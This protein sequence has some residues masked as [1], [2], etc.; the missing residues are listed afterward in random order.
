MFNKYPLRFPSLQIPLGQALAEVSDAARE[1]YINSIDLR[2]KPVGPDASRPCVAE[3]LREFWKTASAARQTAL[4]TLAFKRWKDWNFDAGNGATHVFD[5]CWCEIDYAVMG[6]VVEC[7][8]AKARAATVT[9][10]NNR[11]VALDNNWH[12]SLSDFYSAFNRLVSALQPYLHA[13]RIAFGSDWLSEKTFYRVI[14]DTNAYVLMIY[15]AR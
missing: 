7:M 8:D 15:S 6:Y 5:I 12:A 11:I 10:L 4:W 1:V 9:E 13:D 3:C 2:A 14:D